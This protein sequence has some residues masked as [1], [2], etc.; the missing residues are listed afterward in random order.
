MG[1]TSVEDLAGAEDE[2]RM[3]SGAESLAADLGAEG[4]GTS[5]IINTQTSSSTRSSSSSSNSN[6][7]RSRNPS[8]HNPSRSC[9]SPHLLL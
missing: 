4:S 7:S 9:S 1:I 6:N 5:I 2:G 8:R 3:D